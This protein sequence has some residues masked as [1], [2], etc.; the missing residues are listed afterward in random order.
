LSRPVGQAQI[1][2]FPSPFRIALPTNWR[3]K[4][5]C[6]LVRAPIAVIRL[7]ATTA[8]IAIERE[9]QAKREK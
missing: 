6:C 8:P 3:Y 5:R 2:T 7:C 9:R 1:R 4:N